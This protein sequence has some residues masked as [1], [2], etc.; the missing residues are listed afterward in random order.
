MSGVKV[1]MLT[2]RA[3]HPSITHP[4]IAPF[5][6]RLSSHT[7]PL[8][9]GAVL[10]TERFFVEFDLCVRDIRII[11]DRRDMIQLLI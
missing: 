5:T 1:G 2:V 6:P 8:C 10:L 3:T 7:D 4:P 11:H 9:T